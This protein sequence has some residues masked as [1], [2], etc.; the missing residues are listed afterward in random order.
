MFTSVDPRKPTLSEL[1]DPAY[2]AAP[3]QLKAIS[4]TDAYTDYELDHVEIPMPTWRIGDPDVTVI[5]L[6]GSHGVEF[7]SQQARA[8]VL[9]AWSM[10]IRH[11]WVEHSP[12]GSLCLVANWRELELI[13]LWCGTENLKVEDCGD[14]DG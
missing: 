3:P 8:R 4:L 13:L 14:Y 12:S 2:S 6:N 5:H 10:A 7:I 11:G 1:C 9:I